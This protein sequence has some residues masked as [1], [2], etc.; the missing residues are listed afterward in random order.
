MVS[1]YEHMAPPDE[2]RGEKRSTPNCFVSSPILRG[3]Y[4]GGPQVII[5]RH[6]KS[7]EC[8]KFGATAPFKLRLK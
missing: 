8:L 3:V 1:D 5:L 4:K 7:F 6:L 2:Y